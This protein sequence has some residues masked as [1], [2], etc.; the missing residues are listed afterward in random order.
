MVTKSGDFYLRLEGIL[1]AVN[2]KNHEAFI[3]VERDS[4]GR[5]EIEMADQN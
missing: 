5:M 3:R 1:D 2:C 4:L